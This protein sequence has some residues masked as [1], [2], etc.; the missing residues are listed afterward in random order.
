MEPA[1]SAK[2]RFSTTAELVD[3]VILALPLREMLLYRRVSTLR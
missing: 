2:D 1:R 3:M